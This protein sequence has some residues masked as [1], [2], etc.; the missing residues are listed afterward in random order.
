LNSAN[1]RHQPL[2]VGVAGG[3][4]SGK[5]TLAKAIRE[6][7]HLDCVSYISHDNYYKVRF[8]S[9]PQ[10]HKRANPHPHWRLSMGAQL[11][12]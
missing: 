9:L 6:S 2:V 7:L 11:P 8:F 5:T 12:C 10:H 3:T 4:G 1:D